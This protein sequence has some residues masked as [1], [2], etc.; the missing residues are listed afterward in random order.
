MYA[1]KIH[2]GFAVI[3]RMGGFCLFLAEYKKRS[4]EKIE[5]L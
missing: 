3:M 5:K 4:G 2:R 1:R